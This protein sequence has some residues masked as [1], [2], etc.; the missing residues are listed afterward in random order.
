MIEWLLLILG[1]LIGSAIGYLL[2]LED[3]EDSEKYPTHIEERWLELQRVTKSEWC[4][5]MGDASHRTEWQRWFLN[6]KERR[7]NDEEG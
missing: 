6:I 5:W 2:S 7:K 4:H 1:I 3:D